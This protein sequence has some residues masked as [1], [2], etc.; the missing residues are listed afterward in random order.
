MKLNRLKSSVI[1]IMVML[2]PACQSGMTRPTE[3]V[4]PDPKAAEINVNLGL[5]Y[6]QQ[7]ENKIAM[8]KLQK[9]L[10]QN[11]N[12]PSAHNAIALLYQ[13]LNKL[14]DAEHHFQQA[15]RRAPDYSEAQN[16]YGV[17]LCQQK[18]YDEAEQQFLQAIENP[19]YNRIAPALE[20]AGICANRIPDTNK[21]ETYFRKA[22][23]LNPNLAKSLIQMAKISYDQ[24]R[25]LQARGYIQRYQS[26]ARWTPQ[27]LFT[28]IQIEK[29]LKDYDSVASYALL[30]KGNFPDSEENR[31][32]LRGHY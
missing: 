8:Q 32:V 14:E 23:R 7:G 28:A 2:L 27:A 15:I 11:P 18:R 25:F 26:V 4:A 22:L 9:A 6:L 1:V 21:A 12:L 17:Y 30:L 24:D 5:N 31:A 29:K 19:L 20:N 13:R 16:N 10:K 3:Y